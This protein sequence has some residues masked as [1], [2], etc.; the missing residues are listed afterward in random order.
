MC[1]HHLRFQQYR[2]RLLVCYFCQHLNLGQRAAA[3]R[4]LDHHK[5]IVR[6]T[7]HARDILC[8]HLKRLRAQNHSALAE[9]FEADAIMQTAR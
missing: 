1:Y 3:D 6:Q 5:R 7:K 8:R 4:M 2:Y 9:L